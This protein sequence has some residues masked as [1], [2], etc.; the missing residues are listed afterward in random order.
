MSL[1]M[2]LCAIK[3]PDSDSHRHIAYFASFR[4]R[5]KPL[6]IRMLFHLQRQSRDAGVLKSKV[7]IRNLKLVFQNNPEVLLSNDDLL[8]IVFTILDEHSGKGWRQTLASG[9]WPRIT[10]VVRRKKR[11][12]QAAP[13]R[14]EGPGEEVVATPVR[15]EGE[16]TRKRRAEGFADQ[17]GEQM[18]S[19]NMFLSGC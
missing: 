12:S 19:F 9:V 15:E 13:A 3:E 8:E 10:A 5:M 11:R 2:Q 7:C 17:E 4:C 1:S 18:A 16:T 14:E 6:L